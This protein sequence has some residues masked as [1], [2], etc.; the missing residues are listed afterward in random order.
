MH[1][2]LLHNTRYIYISL[3]TAVRQ[4]AGRFQVLPRSGRSHG[5]LEVLSISLLGGVFSFY[6]T[7]LEV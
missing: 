4:T 5:R 7:L 3:L 2:L 1:R 6:G